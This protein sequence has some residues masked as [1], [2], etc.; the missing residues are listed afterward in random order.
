MQGLVLP[1]ELVLMLIIINRVRVMGKHRNS[2]AANIV[3]WS[4]VI[5]VGAIALFYTVQ[6]IQSGGS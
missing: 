1:L 6:Q 5:I 2:R 3:G 4:T